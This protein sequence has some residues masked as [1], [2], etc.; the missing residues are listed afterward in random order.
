[1]I[2]IIG[3]EG[4][5]EYE[6]AIALK[7]AFTKMWPGCEST[8]TSQDDIRIAVSVKISGYR[9]SDVDIV[10]FCKFGRARKFVPTYPVNDKQGQPVRNRAVVVQN[11]IVAV[12]VKDHSENRVRRTG[13]RIDVRYNNRD[14]WHSATDQNVNQVHSLKNYLKDKAID[15]YVQ[16]LSLIHI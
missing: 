11:L 15:Q 14:K 4:T 7:E 8:P 2:E 10:F 6:A 3:H 5:S 1:M 16:R 12:E 13:D 9:V